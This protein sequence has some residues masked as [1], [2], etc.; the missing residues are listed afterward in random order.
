MK[1]TGNIYTKIY[2][3]DNIKD[4]IMKASLGKRD[5]NYVKKILD[6][7]DFYA[8]KVSVLLKNNQYVASPYTIK[9]I[10]DGASGKE[11]T[12]YKPRCYPL[13]S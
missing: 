3:V 8:N 1:R 6:N 11:R 5:R 7:L 9:K 2:D 10:I 12:I 4:A 13:R